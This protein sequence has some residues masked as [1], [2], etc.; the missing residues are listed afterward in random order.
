MD[1]V[2]CDA[3]WNYDEPD[4]KGTGSDHCD[5][6]K[7]AAGENR[8]IFPDGRMI[9]MDLEMLRSLS[10]VARTIFMSYNRS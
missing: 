3:Q 9:T 8:R 2:K 10:Q 6:G 1:P 7:S 5:R 4:R